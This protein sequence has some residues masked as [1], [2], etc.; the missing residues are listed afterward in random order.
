MRLASSL[1]LLAFGL[2]S[3]SAFAQDAAPAGAPAFVTK[4]GGCAT[5]HGANG[6]STSPAF[7]NLAGQ[8]RSYIE[9]V[10]HAYKSGERKNPVMSVQ[11]ANLSDADIEAAALWFSKQPAKVYVPTNEGKK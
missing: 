1:S 10:L 11:V 4:P 2:A 9:H 5:C 6:V 8:Q 7:P 3:A